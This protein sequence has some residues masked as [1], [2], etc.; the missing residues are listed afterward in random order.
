M[1]LW[2]A[3]Y[4]LVKENIPGLMQNSE[5]SRSPIRCGSYPVYPGRTAQTSIYRADE[6]VRSEQCQFALQ[7]RSGLCLA[8][9]K[10]T[11]GRLPVLAGN[12]V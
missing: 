1:A 12:D 8:Y 11:I 9:W 3:I 10:E 6:T 7:G 5:V 4:G 2:K